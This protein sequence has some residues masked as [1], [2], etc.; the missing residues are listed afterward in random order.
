MTLQKVELELCVVCLEVPALLNWEGKSRRLC[1]AC[2]ADYHRLRTYG[3]APDEYQAMLEEQDHKCRICREPR[4]LFVDHNHL[5]DKVRGLL[6]QRCNSL[7]GFIDHYLD[8]LDAAVAYV[9][10]APGTETGKDSS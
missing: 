8:L 10:R 7:V 2:R 5:T 6:C 9:H 1:K 3:L 4:Q